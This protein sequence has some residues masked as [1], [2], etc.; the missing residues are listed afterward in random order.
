MD[1]SNTG[2]LIIV[3]TPEWCAARGEERKGS[4]EESGKLLEA[5]RRNDIPLALSLVAR[6]AH[7]SHVDSQSGWSA[8]HW[9]AH[10]NS[11]E[12][13]KALIRRDSTRLALNK[14][15][16]DVGCE[17]PMHCA[18]NQGAASTVWVLLREGHDTEVRDDLGNTP[19]HLA[20]ANGHHNVLSILIRDGC[21]VHAINSYKHRPID[22]ATDENCKVALQQPM[23]AIEVISP[24]RRLNMH[25]SNLK[26]LDL[27]ETSLQNAIEGDSYCRADIE[28]AIRD[29]EN[30][31]A[32]ETLIER[33][34]DKISSL[35]MQ[36]KLEEHMLRVINAGPI[37][38]QQSYT[39]YVNN[40]KKIVCNAEATCLIPASLLIKARAVITKSDAEYWLEK[41]TSHLKRIEV[42]CITEEDLVKLWE[43]IEAAEE[44][45]IHP[46]LLKA[47]KA[48]L[49]KA[50]TELEIGKAIQAVP[51]VRLPP[52]L[53]K[54]QK[55]PS[56][57]WGTDDIGRIEETEDYPL[58]PRLEDGE[59]GEYIWVPS[60]SLQKLQ[61][62][63]KRLELAI[64]EGVQIKSDQVFLAQQ[65]RDQLIPN[66][67]ALEEHNNKT[68]DK[69]IKV[70][71]K[72]AA[73]INRKK[74]TKMKPQKLRK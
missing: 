49:K 34:R 71:S 72:L 18:A 60:N 53:K 17:S 62:T 37:T 27:I 20:A 52:V 70:A 64:N 3:P 44:L 40:L 10:Y 23:M 28:L 63:M 13:V 7:L 48:F 12:V 41:V 5:C 68:R 47:S 38:C 31:Y 9:A 67:L 54:G 35:L 29:A 59:R 46:G 14:Q 61:R 57:W 16:S 36:Q 39:T 73:K 24:E 45:D 22:L 51:V 66:L 69:A 11:S 6:D 26:Q 33:G 42:D 30:L 74:K 50:D 56:N 15:I 1:S 21:N 55:C 4:V 43:R 19:A 8:V 65:A 32:S 58:P 25:K 2:A